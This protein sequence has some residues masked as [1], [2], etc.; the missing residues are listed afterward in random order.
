[1]T[2]PIITSLL[3]TDLYKLT[4]MQCVLH[5]FP[6]VMVEYQFKNRTKDIALSPYLDEINHEID[7]LC[8]LHFNK[9]ELA[10]LTS[11][12]Y[13]KPNFIEFLRTFQ[14][15]RPYIKLNK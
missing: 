10:Y 4:M 6:E 8:Q 15:N 11:L 7:A 3:D 14:L 9:D 1:M 5:Q 12:D 13:I 2:Q